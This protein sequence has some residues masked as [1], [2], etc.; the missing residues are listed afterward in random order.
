MAEVLR[1]FI[2]AT[3][4]LEPQRAL[5]GRA[6]AQLPVRVG[7][8]IRRTPPNKA[9]YEDIFERIANCDRFYFILGRDITA[10]AGTEWDIAHQLDIPILALRRVGPLT[11]AAQAFLHTHP[12]QWHPFRNDEEL[13]RLIVR[14]V[15]DRLLHPTNRYGITVGEIEHLRAHLQTLDQT[16]AHTPDEPGGAEGGGILLDDLRRIPI[17]G[18]SLSPPHDAPKS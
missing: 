16:S 1:L 3:R 12:T 18:H 9:V 8:E 10:P 15:I 14:D 11:P 13:V 4:D 6:I 2:S 7:I 17:T 5:I